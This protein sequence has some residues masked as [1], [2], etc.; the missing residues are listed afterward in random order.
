MK[1]QTFLVFCLA[2]LAVIASVNVVMAD[3][4]TLNVEV[5]ANG[6][7]LDPIVGGVP[8]GVIS[9]GHVGETIPI[10][11]QFTLPDDLDDTTDGIEDT[12]KVKVYIEDYR[13]EV[14]DSKIV[15]T[16]LKEDVT[17][18]ERFSLT[19]PSSLDLDDLDEDLNLYVRFSVKNDYV[20]E[21][22]PIKMQRDFE[23]LN[24]LSVEADGKY[25]A[26]DTVAFDVVLQNNG[27][28]RLDNVYVKASIPDLGVEKIVYVGDIVPTE[29]EYSDNHLRDTVNRKVYLNI[30]RNTIPGTYNVEIEA[31]NYDT[32][33]VVEK[34]I[35]INNIDTSVL[36]IVNAKAISTGEETTFEVVLINPNDRMVIYSVVPQETS[37]LILTVSEPIVA[38]PADSSRTVQ[39]KAK[40]TESTEAGT[41]LI[42]VGINS[43]SGFVKQLNFALNVEGSEIM[44]TRNDTVTTLTVVL[45]VIFVVLLIVLIVLLT[46]KPSEDIEEFGETSY[47]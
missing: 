47:Y 30:P 9:V 17:Y 3:L 36:P 40:A 45:A 31:Y 29:D 27:Y 13:S 11:V 4:T 8:S 34:K 1:K 38:V 28:E 46:K 10:E 20:E 23:S 26:G 18:K 43:E 21:A 16:P 44:K 14:Y 32:K 37:G 6:I 41:Y 15:S 12:V 33:K 39:V 25:I 42:S 22:Y 5:K 19:L 35:E 24:I 2:L 7:E